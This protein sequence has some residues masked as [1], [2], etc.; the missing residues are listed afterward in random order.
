MRIDTILN[1][2]DMSNQNDTRA[3]KLWGSSEAITFDA[4]CWER[5][6]VHRQTPTCYVA[7]REDLHMERICYLKS[8]R[9]DSL[10]AAG[11]MQYAVFNSGNATLIT[12]TVQ[13]KMNILPSFT[14]SHVV[15]NLYE[16][17]SSVKHKREAFCTCIF[18]KVLNVSYTSI[19]TLK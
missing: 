13:L 4:Q 9:N 18:K 12:I 8:N 11:N 15:P 14:L 6:Y 2:K 5:K 10:G 7:L 3:D 1:I 17:L 19:L 16:F